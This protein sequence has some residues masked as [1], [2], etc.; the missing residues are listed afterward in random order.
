MPGKV[1]CI[2]EGRKRLNE[3]VIKDKLIDLALLA[4]PEEFEEF[5]RRV[6]Q[7]ATL[8]EKTP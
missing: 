1:V 5:L 3:R 4:S 6:I 8:E 2:N 7:P